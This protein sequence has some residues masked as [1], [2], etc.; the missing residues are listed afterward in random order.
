MNIRPSAPQ[1]C[2]RHLRCRGWACP[3]LFAREA[4]AVKPARRRRPSGLSPSSRAKRP[5]FFFRA[6]LWR[7]GLHSRGTVATNVPPKRL[8]GTEKLLRV[9]TPHPHNF[10]PVIPRASDEVRGLDSGGL[11]RRCPKNLN[12]KCCAQFTTAYKKV[13][14]NKGKNRKCRR[15]DIF[16]EGVPRL[17]LIKWQKVIIF[18]VDFGG[19]RRIFRANE[20]VDERPERLATQ[21]ASLLSR[22][23]GNRNRERRASRF[24]FQFL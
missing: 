23:L 16:G 9:I 19:S 18:R 6:A 15:A 2:L 20:L 4:L 17:C 13:Q 14:K 12:V 22:L 3:A 21:V 11:Y 8:D 5:D 1:F 24:P 10:P 7:V